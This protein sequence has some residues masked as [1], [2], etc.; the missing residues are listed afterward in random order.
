M[1]RRT[2]LVL[3]AFAFVATALPH[4]AAQPSI[5]Q[6]AGSLAFP[7]NMATAVTDV[8]RA[9]DGS[10]YAATSDA[11]LRLP[12]T[13]PGSPRP[14]ASPTS[15]SSGPAGGAGTGVGL[16]IAAVLIGGLILLRRRI[17]RR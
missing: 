13:P 1:A 17:A 5:Q 14:T 11:I 3:V 12:G 9:P 10:I 4:L 7:T 8:A 6:V 15:A 2:L 16:V